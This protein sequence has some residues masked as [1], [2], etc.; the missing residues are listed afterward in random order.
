[1]RVIVST[2]IS[3]T[4]THYTVVDS[5]AKV[6]EMEDVDCGWMSCRNTSL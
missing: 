1:M 2:S 6:A 5:I 4:Y 3:F